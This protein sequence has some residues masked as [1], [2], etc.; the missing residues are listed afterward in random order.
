MH[1]IVLSDMHLSEAAALDA[2][3]PLWMA[4]KH[5]A[6]FIDEDFARLLAH[7]D[8]HVDGPIELVLNGD[9]FD[10]DNVTQL[11]DEPER[12]VHWLARLRGLASEEW[13]SNFKMRCIIADHATWFAALEWFIDRGHHVVFVIGNHDA[14]LYWPSVQQ[15]VREALNVV[16]ADLV[17]FCDW[18][19]LSAGDTYISHGHQYDPNCSS[20]DPL[21]PLI[22]VHGRPRV[23]IPFGDLAGRYMLNGM[24]YFNP[25]ATENYIMTGREYVRFF[26][27]YMLRTQPLLI[28]SWFWSAVATLFISMRDHLRP[29]LRDP[30][31]VEEDVAVIAEHANATPS[32]VRQLAALCVPPAATRPLRV[33]RE[34][35]LDRGFLFLAMLFAAWQIVLHV[36]IAL[37]ISPLW[38]FAAAAVLIPP[39]I[40]YS[41]SVKPTVFDTPL[42]SEH[43]AELIAQITGAKNVVFGHTHQPAARDV[44]PVRLVNGGFWSAAFTAPDCTERIGTQTFVWLQPTPAGD[45]VARLYEWQPGGDAPQPY[46]V[47]EAD[48]VTA[49]GLSV[50]TPSM[51]PPA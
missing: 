5:R 20:K 34:L 19:Y 42:L 16:T 14:E 4:Y 15:Q 51:A 11:P 1:T 35:W 22:D 40:I 8:Q 48:Q 9:I 13:M 26:F 18:F 17:R 29:P 10:F 6:H 36:N 47:E 50:E 44:G 7:F 37:P 45:R 25:N 23:R 3:R 38:V 2:K 30:L 24:G 33:V 39:Y 41:A 43:R 21:H 31:H 12:P 27:R 28:W 32:M 46:L 49:S